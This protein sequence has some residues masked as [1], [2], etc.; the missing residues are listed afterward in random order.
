MHDDLGLLPDLF[1]VRAS[2]PAPVPSSTSCR[3]LLAVSRSNLGA[4]AR[5]VSA[6]IGEEAQD[7]R[8]EQRVSL[9]AAHGYD[10]K[11]ATDATKSAGARPFG[12]AQQTRGARVRVLRARAAHDGTT[13]PAQALC[14]V[15][16]SRAMLQCAVHAA[17]HGAYAAPCGIRVT[18]VRRVRAMRRRPWRITQ[19]AGIRDA[20]RPPAGVVQHVRNGQC[21]R[22]LAWQDGE[23]RRVGSI[24]SL[25]NGALAAA[26]HGGTMR[27]VM[28]LRERESCVCVGGKGRWRMRVTRG[29]EREETAKM[30]R[31]EAAY[32]GYGSFSMRAV[33][34]VGVKSWCAG[35][36]GG[37]VRG[38][39]AG[40]DQSPG[41]GSGE[42]DEKERWARERHTHR[43]AQACSFYLP[44]ACDVKRF[45]RVGTHHVRAAAGRPSQVGP[46]M[47]GP[48]LSCCAADFST[49]IMGVG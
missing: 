46:Y 5:T 42:R 11:G 9:C 14:V 13:G 3:H 48:G 24:C 4:L 10:H 17:A 43:H 7:T 23:G 36:S 22:R 19:K 8:R 38:T 16:T 33:S 34:K 35:F 30:W 45:S 27:S 1:P 26:G 2:T 28:L 39:R 31:T 37:V 12:T 41:G 25:A 6:T 18:S 47:V 20:H 32:H 49:E 29:E 40:G 44:C 21:L 15:A